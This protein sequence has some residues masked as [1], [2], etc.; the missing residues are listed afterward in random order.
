MAKEYYDILGLQKGASVDEVK[1]AYRK[2]SKEL[3]PDKHKG[4]KKAEDRF[5]EVNEAYETLSNPQ[6]KQMYDQFGSAG[7]GAGGA[8]GFGGFDFSGFAGG[9]GGGERVDFSDLFEGF[10]GGGGGRGGQ[11]RSQ[12]GEDKEVA[13]TVPFTDAVKGAAHVIRVRKLKSCDI[14]KGS[15]AQPGSSTVTCGD[16]GGTGQVTR[17]AQSF[18]G[19][20]QQRVI[21]P[22]C[23]G[24]GKVP[25]K[26]CKTCD[27]EG[28]VMD[29]VELSIDIPA[30]IDDGQTLRLRGQGDAGR[31]G[32]E[33]GDLYV[34][35]RITPDD[36]FERQGADIR[37]EKSISVL[38]ALLGIELP[39]ETVHG[40]ETISVPAGTQPGQV[41]RIRHKGMPVLSTN[42]FGDHYVT[43]EVEIPTRLGKDERKLLEEWRKLRG[44]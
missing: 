31:Q 15:G 40:E 17:T 36:R 8:G 28:R 7:P 6:K 1:Q 11:R 39:V 3:H 29:T 33:A 37:T 16:C 22:K 44:K 24:A 27:G 34:H 5:K 20:M 42:R 41:F 26:T 32:A 2:L 18:F 14:C 43:V 21:C 10:F 23:Q 30:G 12:K 35:V 4:D 19:V 25:E 13:I 38:D 9:G